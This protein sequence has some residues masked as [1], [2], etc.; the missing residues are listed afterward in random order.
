MMNMKQYSNKGFTLIELLVASTLITL[1]MASVYTLFYSTIR[2]WR[3]VER[4][5]NVHE[6]GRTAVAL[7]RRELTNLI[8][9]AAHLAEGERGNLTVFL[10]AEPFDTELPE[11]R[12]VMRVRY[13][14]DP[15]RQALVRAEALVDGALPRSPGPNGE[16][17]HASQIPVRAEQ[18]WVIA[19]HVQDFSMRFH[20]MPR[21]EPPRDPFNPP[22]RIAPL[23]VDR[24]LGQ[25]DL[26]LPQA[27]ELRMTLHPPELDGR[28]Y[29]VNTMIPLRA[30]EMP[31]TERVLRDRMGGTG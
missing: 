23:V 24:H 15:S 20:W 5:Y 17:L 1:V 22:Q 2:A 28:S 8:S 11:G 4:G 29:T 6:E 19:E 21:P 7:M 26:G 12:H 10:V 9:D 18:S 13:E 14:Y 27:L 31:W 30:R 16:V 25:W 3:H